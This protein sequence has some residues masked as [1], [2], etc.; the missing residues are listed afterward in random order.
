M[1]ANVLFLIKKSDVPWI[2]SHREVAFLLCA[3]NGKK[4]GRFF[5]FDTL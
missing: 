1:Q 3:R 4:H 2:H 5:D